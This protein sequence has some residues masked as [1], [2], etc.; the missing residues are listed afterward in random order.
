[1]HIKVPSP[2]AIISLITANFVPIF[3]APYQS[4][5]SLIF[6]YWLES[7]VVGYYNFLKIRKITKTSTKGVWNFVV[8]YTGLLAIYL[9]FLIIIFGKFQSNLPPLFA[10]IT[11]FIS[12]FISHGISYKYNY[13]G[14]YEY[15][16][17]NIKQ[18][19][20]APLGRLVILHLT[21]AIGGFVL[22]KFGISQPILVLFIFIKTAVDLGAH[23]REHTVL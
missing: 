1:M 14:N 23:Y 9:L 17:T 15:K 18:Q 12:F 8:F 20:K 4:V 5:F 19:S 3:W 21:I 2:L 6:I 11:T 7:T 16:H 10:I 13:L 22:L